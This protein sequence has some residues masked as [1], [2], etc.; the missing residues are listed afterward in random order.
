MHIHLALGDGTASRAQ[1]RELISPVRKDD[2][3]DV[4]RWF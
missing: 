2:G 3:E 1:A 4:K